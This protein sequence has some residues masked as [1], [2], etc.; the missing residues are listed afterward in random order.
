MLF[1][2]RLVVDGAARDDKK[3]WLMCGVHMQAVVARLVENR[4]GTMLVVVDGKAKE[5]ERLLSCEDEGMGRRRRKE[6]K[7]SLGLLFKKKN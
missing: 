1:R 2:T 5:K 7:E 6:N 4:Q 3:G